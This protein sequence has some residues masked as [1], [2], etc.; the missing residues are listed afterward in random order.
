MRAASLASVFAFAVLSNDDPVKI[1][2]IGVTERR[3]SASEDL[4][5]SDIRVLL[6]WLTYCEPQAPERDVVGN[7]LRWKSVRRGNDWNG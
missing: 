6:K 2:S 7:V 4:G 3:L 1:T 5:W